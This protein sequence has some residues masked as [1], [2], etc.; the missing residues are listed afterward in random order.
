MKENPAMLSLGHRGSRLC[1]GVTRRELLRV[2]A[3]AWA[4]LTLPVLLH[5]QA[6][7]APARP[8][9]KSCIQLFMWGGPAHQETFDLKPHAPDGVGSMFAPI[10]TRVPGILICEHL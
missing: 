5:G 9:A 4:G 10:P 6:S 1:D 7:G 8:K 2:G 3:L